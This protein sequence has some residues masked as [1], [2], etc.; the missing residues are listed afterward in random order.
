MPLTLTLKKEYSQA[1]NFDRFPC[2]TGF[3]C[4]TGFDK[5][6]DLIFMRCGNFV[7]ANFAALFLFSLLVLLFEV[8]DY[9]GVG[10]CGCVADGA[11]FGD[12]AQ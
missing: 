1:P 3:P 9:C 2:I 8:G 7:M 6:S 11:A 5:L 4:N 12:V 10:Q